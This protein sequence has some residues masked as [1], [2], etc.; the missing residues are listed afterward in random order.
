MIEVGIASDVAL[1]EN[2]TIPS[3]TKTDLIQLDIYLKRNMTFNRL[4]FL[5]FFL[6]AFKMFHNPLRMLKEYARRFIVFIIT[7][8]NPRLNQIIK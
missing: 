6:P 5:M 1:S 2:H 7:N 8:R 3:A 4:T